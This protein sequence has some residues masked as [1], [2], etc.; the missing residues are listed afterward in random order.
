M[1]EDNVTKHEKTHLLDGRD[2]VWTSAGRD[3]I[4]MR[5]DMRTSGEVVVVVVISDLAEYPTISFQPKDNIERGM[6]AD[7]I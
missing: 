3:E 7:I 1:E 6:F 4:V 5:A 2:E